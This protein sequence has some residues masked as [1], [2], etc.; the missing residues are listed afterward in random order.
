[1]EKSVIHELLFSMFIPFALGG[2]GDLPCRTNLGVIICTST[3]T[4]PTQAMRRVE[5]GVSLHYHIPLPVSQ[6]E[7]VPYPIMKAHPYP[8]RRAM[9]ISHW[10]GVSLIRRAYP[11]LLEG[12]I[13]IPIEGHIPNRRAYPASEHIPSRRAYPQHIP[14]QSISHIRAYPSET[15]APV[16]NS[17]P[18][19][20]STGPKGFFRRLANRERK[21]R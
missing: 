20:I 19:A 17:M 2:G 15:A 5:D 10:E 9:F 18:Q 4:G 11:H 12:H 8:I 16:R 14:Y 7:G 1:M 6:C 3:E 13:R 21:A